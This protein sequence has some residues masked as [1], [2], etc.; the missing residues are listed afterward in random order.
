MVQVQLAVSMQKNANCSI[1]ISLYKSQVQVD[2]G[3]PHKTTW[4]EINR[5]ECG[6]QPQAH[7]YRGNFPQH[8]INTYALRSRIDKWNL[9]KLQ[10]F[11]KAKNTVSK[12]ERPNIQYIQPRCPSTEGWMQKIWYIYTMDFYSTIKTMNL[13]NSLANLEDIILSEV[14]QSQKKSLDMHS[15]IS[16]YQPRN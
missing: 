15:L 8:N 2:K 9:I 16:G 5:K 4:P 12:T 14:T 10:S 3:P 13:W 6:E 11:C 1:L 7:R